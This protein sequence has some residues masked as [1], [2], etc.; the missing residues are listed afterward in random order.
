MNV[1][2]NLVRLININYN[3]DIKSEFLEDCK[4]IGG[5]ECLNRFNNMLSSL[6][7]NPTECI[8]NI[9]WQ[10]AVLENAL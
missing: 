6:R 9:L 2:Q 4:W 8:E 5:G 10:T 1:H 7:K 3:R